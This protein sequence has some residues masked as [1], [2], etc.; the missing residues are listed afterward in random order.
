MD[1]SIKNYINRYKSLNSKCKLYLLLYMIQSISAGV[2]FYIAIFLNEYLLLTTDIISIIVSSF[3]AG[4]LLGSWIAAK[5][6]DNTNPFKLSGISLF[7]QAFCFFF[8][9]FTTKIWCIT[10]IMLILGVSNYVYLI[11]NDYL[12]IVLAGR[13]ESERASAISLLN[14]S[15]NIGLGVGGVIVSFLSKNNPIFMFTIIGA[16]LCISAL[17]YFLEQYDKLSILD[18]NNN[19]KESETNIMLYRL[20]LSVIFL[21]GLIF[22]QQ[23]VSYSLFLTTYYGETGASFIFMLNAF[24]I[25]FFLPTVTNYIIKK[26]KVLAMGF[27][28]FLL[29]GGML[30]LI[31]ASSAYWLVIIICVITTLG[32]M[33]GT[34]LSQLI[35]FQ[36][37]SKE[38]KGRA[39]GYYKFLY[40]FG[41]V[42]G[43]LIGGKIQVNL[44]ANYV[45]LFCGVIGFF[46][47]ILCSQYERRSFKSPMLTA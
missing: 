20:S 34:T 43:T 16:T 35:C 46:S 31:I 21:L 29:G 33:L 47:L 12:I 38:N 4:N 2:A 30:A 27:G 17:F 8:I 40:A 7:F 23:R 25:I 37:V 13:M 6:V 41:T 5:L 11:C 3:V 19:E 18:K 32:E 45:W 10:I 36:Y 14:V 15:S 42:L 28:A 39:M 24:L 26:N 9:C 22:A 1:I 44:G